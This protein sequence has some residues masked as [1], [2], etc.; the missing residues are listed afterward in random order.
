MLRNWRTGKG[1]ESPLGKWGACV[2]VCVCGERVESRV[3]RF[4]CETEEM[5]LS[6]GNIT[7]GT[8]SQL[9]MGDS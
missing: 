6:P 4:K 8:S 1:G 5:E 7:L 9:E 3:H 2:C